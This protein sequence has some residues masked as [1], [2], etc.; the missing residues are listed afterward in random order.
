M[1]FY[2]AC[3]E[4]RIFEE[5]NM[6]S[7]SGLCLCVN[8]STGIRTARYSARRLIEGYNSFTNGVFNQFGPV[9]Y[10][11]FGHKVGTMPVYG[12]QADI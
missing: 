2:L 10:F 1:Q 4:K 3:E 5:N 6:R 12:F 8:P 7:I 9:M 11:E